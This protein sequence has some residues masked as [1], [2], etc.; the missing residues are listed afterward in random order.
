MPDTT[1][2]D[3]IEDHKLLEQKN[4]PICFGV[5]TYLVDTVITIH[6]NSKRKIELLGCTTCCHWWHSPA[7]S[8]DLLDT[9][10]Q[11][12]SEYVVPKN[13]GVTMPM[14]SPRDKKL[15]EEIFTSVSKYSNKIT[16][17][18]KQF[19]YLELGVGSGGLFN[20]F[21]KKANLSYGVEPGNWV[22]NDSQ[23][24]VKHINDLPD[25]V[26]FDMIIAHDVLEHLH[27]PKDTL[28]QLGRHAQKD[29]IIH[30]TFPNK[31][32]YKAKIQKGKW[33]MVRPFGHLHYFSAMS[34]EKMFKNAGWTILKLKANRISENNIV[35]LWRDFDWSSNHV[36]YR[37]IK[38]LLIGQI[39][40]GKDQWTVIAVKA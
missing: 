29:C 28:E 30:C 35:D 19:N 33:H 34:T 20:F 3:Y 40:L 38:S 16:L 13:Y 21:K 17:N 2:A 25:N 26:K 11:N 23:T 37:L 32:S 1:T 15:W 31:D 4:C 5:K 6:P 7:P 24:I 27:T 10:Y 36:I 9:F 12:G 18:G 14:P 22:K 8:Q 39:L